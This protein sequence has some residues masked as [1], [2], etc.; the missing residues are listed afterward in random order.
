ML[1]CCGGGHAMKVTVLIRNDHDAIKALFE[2]SRKASETR[3]QNGKKDLFN[4]IRRELLIHTQVEEDVFYPALSTTSSVRADEL[5]ATA[6]NEHAAVQELL[7]ELAG[8]SGSEKNFDAKMSAMIE[9]VVRHIDM[10]EDLIFDEARKNLPEY[11]LEE[12]GL[13][14]EDRRKILTTIAA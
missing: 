11:R 6:K 2:K 1:F 12:L 8:M 3:T 13:E 10:E 4:Q 9:Q 14:M 7:Q 5:V